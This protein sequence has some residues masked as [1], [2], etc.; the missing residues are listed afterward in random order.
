VTCALCGFAYG[1]GGDSCKEHGCPVAFGTCATRHC[2]RCGY[3]VPD[4]SKSV[5]AGLVRRLL[6]RRQPL[7]AG[8]VAELSSGEKGV[9]A[10]LEGD[11]EL[12]SRLIAQGFAPGVEVQLLQRTPTYVV[13]VGETTVAVE[14]RVAE[15]IVLRD[16]R[17]R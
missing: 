16:A 12:L 10:R 4:E 14:H 8:T 1:P 15:A 5:M 17:P 3:T 11:P 7:A 13:E 9:V 6:R 2:P